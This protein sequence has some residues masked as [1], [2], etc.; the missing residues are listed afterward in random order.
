MYAGALPLNYP[1]EV[2]NNRPEN[3][4]CL[5]RC[6]Q[7]KIYKE[8]VKRPLRKVKKAPNAVK[9]KQVFP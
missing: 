2:T 7:D 8:C 5:F 1:E 6:D 9:D 4:Y 3:I